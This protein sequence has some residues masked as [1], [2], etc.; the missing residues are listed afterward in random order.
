MNQPLAVFSNDWHLKKENKD[1][2]IDLV[3]QKCKLSNKA[4]ALI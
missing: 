4:N 3:T 2:I 1:Q